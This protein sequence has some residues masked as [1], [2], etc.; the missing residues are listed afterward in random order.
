MS[1]TEFQFVWPWW[2]LGLLF[3]PILGWLLGGS[4]SAATIRF[5][6]LDGAR[7]LGK[8]ARSGRGGWR[9]IGWLLALALFFVALARPRLGNTRDVTESSGIDIVLALDMSRS[10][11]A[12][13]FTLGGKRVNRVVA[14]KDV[15]RRFIEGRPNDRIGIVAFAGLP[16]LVSPLTLDH[17]WLE[18]NLE[19]L[20]VGL[21]QEGTAIAAAIGSAANRL[22]QRPSKSK[23]MILLT[24]GDETVQSNITPATAAEAAKTLGIKIY[25]IA[26]GTRG[27]APTPV[28]RDIFGNIRYRNTPVT[29]NEEALT[30]IARIGG[31]RF[32]RATDTASLDSIFKSID[33]L[34][35]TQLKLKRS[36][37][38]REIFPWIILAGL[39][40]AAAQ[41]IY[42][43]TAGRT[44][45]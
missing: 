25:T 4:R 3:L 16:Y 1:F 17:A 12:E 15:T 39:I 14:V 13:D 38:W 19:R 36:V 44:T 37:R 9:Q 43:L 8:P 2:L 32:F 27:L 26:A 23:I 35:K 30:E 5:S 45:P 29:V 42:A 6:S 34:E 7:G 18:K 40:V 21:V 28:G 22:K 31:G 24:D 10:M 33:E 20:D 11:L 41:T